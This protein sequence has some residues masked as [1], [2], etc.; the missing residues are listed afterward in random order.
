MR[1]SIWSYDANP[2]VDRRLLKLSLSRCEADVL[3]GRLVWIDIQE[4]SKGCMTRPPT[5]FVRDSLLLSDGPLGVGNL[6]PFARVQKKIDGG[7]HL[8]PDKINYPIPACGAR[9]RPMW[10]RQ[11]NALPLEQVQA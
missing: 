5:G 4:K 3:S 2:A 10:V 1:L 9:S 7:L 8:A 11:V 6:L